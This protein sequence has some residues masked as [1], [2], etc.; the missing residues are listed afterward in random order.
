MSPLKKDAFIVNNKVYNKGSTL[1]VVNKIEKYVV[2]AAITSELKG[3]LIITPEKNENFCQNF[4]L[5]N[6]FKIF[7]GFQTSKERYL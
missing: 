6:T 2:S 3:V 1:L 5:G 7:G 4:L